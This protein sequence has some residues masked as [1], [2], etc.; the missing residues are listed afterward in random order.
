ML[1]IWNNPGGWQCYFGRSCNIWEV[2]PTSDIYTQP[3]V[4]PI[5]LSPSALTWTTVPAMYSWYLELNYSTMLSLAWWS[6]TTTKK[7]IQINLSSFQWLILTCLNSDKSENSSIWPSLAPGFL[8]VTTLSVFNMS[9]EQS[10]CSQSGPW[11]L[12]VL[13]YFL[14]PFSRLTWRLSLRKDLGRNGYLM[15]I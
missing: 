8:C 5:L 10:R 11:K 1:W 7:K 13:W 2:E 14:V 15:D 6:G 3:R 4:L 12:V 9:L